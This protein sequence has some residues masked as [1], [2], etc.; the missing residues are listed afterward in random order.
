MKKLIMTLG[1]LA[2]LLAGSMTLFA[3][4]GCCNDGKCC[5]D[6]CNCAC[7]KK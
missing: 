2:T 3:G 4:D 7:C 6:D 5:K 1:L